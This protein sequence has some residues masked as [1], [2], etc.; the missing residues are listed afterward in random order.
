[1]N[2]QMFFINV[3]HCK[4][5]NFPKIVS[6]FNISFHFRLKKKKKNI[7]GIEFLEMVHENCFYRNSRSTYISCAKEPNII[8]S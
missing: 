8:S 7:Y 2:C 5:I 1:M 4:K 6:F 3:C